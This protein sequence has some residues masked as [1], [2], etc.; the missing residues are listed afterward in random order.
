VFGNDLIAA[1]LVQIA[2]LE[3][4]DP[5]APQ[6]DLQADRQDR[7]VA[8]PGDR[9]LRRHVGQFARLRFGGGEG[10]ALVA[11]DRQSLDLADRV[12][13]GEPMPHQ[14][15]IERGLCREPAADRRSRPGTSGIAIRGE[16][17]RAAPGRDARPG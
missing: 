7:A 8:Q 3:R 11:I 1:D 16:D 14:V 2:D 9:V 12:L 5:G 6:P 13:R 15:L 17:R 10:R 4:G